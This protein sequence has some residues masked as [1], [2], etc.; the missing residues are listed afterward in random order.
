MDIHWSFI[1]IN[2]QI[3]RMRRNDHGTERKDKVELVTDASP[4]N[5]FHVFWALQIW[6]ISSKVTA[7]SS[8]VLAEQQP[9][10][11]GVELKQEPVSPSSD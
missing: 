7:Y 2:I 10:G 5:S 3:Y 8:T 6:F 11:R 1:L 4:T 9:V